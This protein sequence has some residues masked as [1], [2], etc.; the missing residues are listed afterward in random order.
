M[1]GITLRAHF[2]WAYLALDTL[3]LLLLTL[4]IIQ[5]SFSIQLKYYHHGACSYTA[6]HLSLHEIHVLHLI[7]RGSSY[8]DDY[9]NELKRS[10][11][12][13]QQLCLLYTP[14]DSS[15]N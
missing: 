6:S 15:T 4:D 2:T 14:V 8:I 12:N 10:C 7:V 3:P 5:F 11:I 9:L 1:S 13:I